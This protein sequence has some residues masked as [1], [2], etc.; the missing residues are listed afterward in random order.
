MNITIYHNPGC[1]KS[2]KTLEL[3]E[4]HGIEPKIVEYLRQP[5][6]AQTLLRL[7]ETLKVPLADLLR[8]SEEPISKGAADSLPLNEDAALGEP[9]CMTT[10]GYCNAR[11]LWMKT[12]TGPSSVG[13]RKTFLRSCKMT[14]ILVL[15]YSRSGSVQ[16]LAREVCAGIDSVSGAAAQ[17]AYGTRS[18]PQCN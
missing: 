10:P 14:E 18:D 7:A 5:P 9:G 12:G 1:S 2:R 11:S 3:I 4:S 13:R 8:K 16:A 15:Y 17:I 6:D